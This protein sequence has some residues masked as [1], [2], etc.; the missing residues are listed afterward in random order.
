MFISH[1]SLVPAVTVGDTKFIFI[2]ELFYITHQYYR[3]GNKVFIL[4]ILETAVQIYIK[5]FV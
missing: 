3:L 1:L 4:L 2:S 5:G